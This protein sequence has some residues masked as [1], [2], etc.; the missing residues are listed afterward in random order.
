M[1]KMEKIE[2]PLFNKNIVIT[3]SK[4]QIVKVKNLFQNKGAKIFDFP[5]LI[6]EFPDNLDPLD[7]ALK[8]INEF[9]WI[10]FTSSNGIKFVEK[11]L[12][13]KGLCLK[14]C[15]KTLK[16]AVVGEKTSQTLKELGIEADYIPPDF[17]AESLVINFPTSGYGLKVL[18]PRVQSGGRNFIA[19]QFRNSG[20]N[21]LEVPAYE[22]KC[23]ESIPIETIEAFKKKII[24]AIIFSSG[25]TV[26]NSAFLLEKE[27]GKE[28]LKM[29]KDVKLFSI[30]PQ[31]SLV[32]K[33]IFGRVDKEANKYSFEGLLDVA[34]DS[35]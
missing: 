4:D 25:K 18:I 2:Y 20:A 30:G 29:L 1:K 14:N 12:R 8:E 17:I 10:I 34:I 33:E 13:D 24:D 6:I 9:H 22:S 3:R 16:I 28:W 32:C 11:R 35:L 21:V 27:F 31:T 19:E 15:T 26:K 7:D 5:A 23:P